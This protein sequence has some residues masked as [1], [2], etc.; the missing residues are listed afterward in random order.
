MSTPEIEKLSHLVEEYDWIIG[1]ANYD[2][3]LHFS[4]YYLRASTPR[5]T[6]GYYPGYSSIFAFYEDFNERYYLR[7]DECEASA[8]AIVRHSLRDPPWL[9]GI[10]DEIVHR[11]DRL[12]S[13]FNARPNRSAFRRMQTEELLSLYRRHHELHSDLYTYA[14]VPEALDRGVN[15]FTAHLRS[16]LVESHLS[17]T[18]VDEVFSALTQPVNPSVLAQE[19]LDFDR[20]VRRTRH[21]QNVRSLLLSFPRK[22]QLLMSQSLLSRIQRHVDKWR[23]LDYHGYGTRR[24]TSKSDAIERLVQ[25]LQDE[26]LEQ[27]AQKILSRLA[28]NRVKKEVLFERLKINNAY[29]SLFEIY[30]EIGATKLYR[31][32]A[33]LRNFYYLD[34]LLEDIAERLG[35]DEWTVR[36]M[37]PEEVMSSLAGDQRPISSALERRS[38]CMFVLSND[39]ETL[40]SDDHFHDIR[41]RLEAQAAPHMDRRVLKG[42]IASRGKVQ[43]TCKIVIRSDGSPVQFEKGAILVS[44]STDPDLL[45]FL[46][47][48]GGVLTQQGGV[49]SHAAIIC[50]EIGVP[51]IIGIEGLLDK[52]KDGDVVEV[53]AFTGIVTLVG[54]QLEP[55]PGLLFEPG[56]NNDTQKVGAKAANLGFLLNRGF[57]VPPFVLLRLEA[58]EQFVHKATVAM[59][60]QF[61][62]WI[63]QRLA[64]GSSGTVAIRS[65]SIGEDSAVSSFAGEF[66]T[67][68]DVSPAALWHALKEF[69]EKNRRGRTGADY[70]G[71]IIVQKMIRGQVGGVCLTSHVWEGQNDLLVIEMLP[72]GSERVTAGEGKPARIAIKKETLDI[73][74]QSDSKD[75]A[76]RLFEGKLH[77][78]VRIFSDIEE[79]FG[80]AVDIE[81][82]LDGTTI[83]IL[84]V[85][86]IVPPNSLGRSKR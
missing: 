36:C 58:A 59:Q 39:A 80:T 79:S 85:R 33:Q 37:L 52:L 14:R 55:P 21:E 53:D 86:P 76:L 81:W 38:G 5:R 30:A 42:I 6:N 9:E 16:H 50:K 31:R 46:A 22:A 17:E 72:D 83:H 11:S 47:V 1:A 10:L 73:V 84:Q 75:S 19:L 68:L 44:E 41:R 28:A 62:A 3:D 35:I 12:Q 20:I 43:G 15:Y 49:T 57:A 77:E 70:K 60:E 40:R 27:R 65:S 78:A 54:K 34:M 66:N 56:L 82:T 13:V 25:S 61:A 71:A 63:H 32:Y 51:A 26:T 7:R 24:L 48:A 67:S 64:L 23:Y 69:I 74:D 45:K 8:R 2:E 29:R 18:D 4:S